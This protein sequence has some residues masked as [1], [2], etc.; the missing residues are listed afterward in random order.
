M[1]E[2]TSERSE[3]KSY[4]F[5]NMWLECDRHMTEVYESLTFLASCRVDRRAFPC[6]PW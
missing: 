2:F 3:V 5:K 4:K 6:V 1:R